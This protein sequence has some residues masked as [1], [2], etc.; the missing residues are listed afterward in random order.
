MIF[1][2]LTTTLAIACSLTTNS[3]LSLFP[4]PVL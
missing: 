2:S 4:G 3:C 1:G